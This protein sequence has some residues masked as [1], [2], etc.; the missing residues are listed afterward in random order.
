MDLKDIH[1]DLENKTISVNKGEIKSI[2]KALHNLLGDDIVDDFEILIKDETP[3]KEIK[4]EI[5][6][7]KPLIDLVS[8]DTLQNSN[9]EYFSILISLS[10][11]TGGIAN[12]NYYY[13]YSENYN[14]IIPIFIEKVKMNGNYG[15]IIVSV[16]VGN[17]SLLTSLY[18]G[19]I[20]LTVADATEKINRIGN[21]N[22]NPYQVYKQRPIE[23]IRINDVY[24]DNNI[25]N[26]SY[27]LN[28][29]FEGISNDVQVSLTLD[30]LDYFKNPIKEFSLG[31]GNLVTVKKFNMAIE[32]FDEF[33]YFEKSII[34]EG[35]LISEITDNG[36]YYT[37]D[38]LSSITVNIRFDNYVINIY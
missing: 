26:I 15:T 36:D 33:N 6:N 1:I 4:K 2:L 3:K 37:D 31:R 5:K 14:Q 25:R 22:C 23:N 32:Y 11:N 17:S 19:D 7:F 8:D 13:I 35:G 38:S 16:P 30:K 34:F 27:Q 28:N 20:Y 21:L 24:I 29:S 18:S 9:K 10:M 12:K